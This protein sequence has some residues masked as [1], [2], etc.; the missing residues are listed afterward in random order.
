VKRFTACYEQI[1]K[2]NI[3][4]LNFYYDNK[5]MTGSSDKNKWT[6]WIENGIAEDYINYH[7][8]SEFKNIQR[9]GFGAFGNVYRAAWESSETVVALKSFEID[10]CIMREIVNEV[11]NYIYIIL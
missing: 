2:I 3:V 1:K 9:I 7:N 10:N 6:Q 5:K 4:H 8:Y 11:G